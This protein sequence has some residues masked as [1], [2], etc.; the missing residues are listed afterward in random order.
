MNVE[1]D[2]I[3]LIASGERS[4]RF[5]KSIGFSVVGRTDRGYDLLY[6][7]RGHGIT[8]EI[9]VDGTHPAR[10]DRPEG[11]G[12]RHL[13]F[14]VDS[15]EEAASEWGITV[16]PIR[17][18]NGRRFTFFRDPDGQPIELSEQKL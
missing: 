11:L 6:V 3:A 13:S 8:L 16:E 17:E 4:V 18:K 2:H 9:F 7:L 12:L 14:R 10:L 15:I 5:Y 1:L